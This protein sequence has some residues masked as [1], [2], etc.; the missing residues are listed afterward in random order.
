MNKHED[1]PTNVYEVGFHVVSS[2]PEEEVGARV[3][4]VHDV[5][6]KHGGVIISE[7]FPKSMEL[8]YPMVKVS[9][10]QRKTY[11]TSYFGWVKYEGP[12]S[13]A[14]EEKKALDAED[15]I[16]RHI[17]LKTVK[18]NTLMPKK[19]IA[20]AGRQDEREERAPRKE[21]K[22]K[23]VMTDAD[24]DKTIDELSGVAPAIPVAPIESKV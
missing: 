8:A 14:I 18:E 22:E 3:A 17:I 6:E 9:N 11:T 4:H 13:S 15:K 16:L 12:T 5:I 10:N 7:D 20:Q 19:L 24:L 21:E 1:V 23:P 2:V